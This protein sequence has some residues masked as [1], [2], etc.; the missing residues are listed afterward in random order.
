[1][2]SASS[3][4]FADHYKIQVWQARSLAADPTRHAL[5]S[6]ADAVGLG[7]FEVLGTSIALESVTSAHVGLDAATSREEIIVWVPMVVVVAVRVVAIR[8]DLH[9]PRTSKN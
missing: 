8:F 2:R 3:I 6:L 9:L 7:S 4:R 1:M 5:N